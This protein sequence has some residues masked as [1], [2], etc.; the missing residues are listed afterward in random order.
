MTCTTKMQVV[1]GDNIVADAWGLGDA[2]AIQD[3][4]GGGLPD[5]TCA[6]TA[7]HAVRQAKALAKNL[8]AHL[9]NQ[10][11]NDY[12]HKS[13]G[14]VAGLGQWI[15][16]YT[17][18]SKKWGFNGLLAWCGHR[19]YH[20]FA[21]PSFERKFRIW[22]DWI[23]G[24]I[25]GRDTSSTRRTQSPRLFFEAFALRPDQEPEKEE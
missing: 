18:G 16:T 4:S 25:L 1:D 22:G 24:L 5:G 19:F 11:L 7:Q 14:A 10:P 8:I 13:A 9:R 23:W 21:M 20:G 12:R 15:G 6:P 2:T 3:L 17:S